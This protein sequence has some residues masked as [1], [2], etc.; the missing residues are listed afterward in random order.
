MT[1]DIRDAIIAELTDMVAALI[2]NAHEME[3]LHE[4]HVAV[5]VENTE[6][7]ILL[8]EHRRQKV[9]GAKLKTL[10]DTIADVRPRINQVIQQQRHDDGRSS[11]SPASLK[12]IMKSFSAMSQQVADLSD[13]VQTSIEGPPRPHASEALE[14]W[15]DVRRKTKVTPKKINT[16]YNRIKDFIAFVG[17][18][19]VDKYT[20]LEFQRWSNL[21][22]R[23]P[24]LISVV[25][26]LKGKTHQQAADHNDR[27]K[28]PRATM[29]TK[30]I[31]TNYFSPLKHFFRQMA[32]EHRFQSPF[33]DADVRMDG[34]GS[35]KRR[36]FKVEQLNMWFAHAAQEERAEMIWLPLL[37]AI[38]GARIA[39][40]I[41][42]QGRDIYQMENSF[43]GAKYWVID[44]RFELVA[45]DGGSEERKTK[46]ET[47]KRII[48]LHE[49][50]TEAGFIDYVRSRR[51]ADWLFPASF[52]HGKKRV[53]DPPRAA[54]KRMNRMLKDVG[55]HKP[56]ERVF[57]STRHT[58]KDIMRLARVDG[59]TSDLQT[60][61]AFKTVSGS[62]GAKDLEELP[63]EIEV[64]T[65][66]PLPEGLDL[67]PYMERNDRRKSRQ[68]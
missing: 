67:S 47:S 39:E 43:T 35:V 63:T 51:A 38:T 20:F 59:R 2:T 46:T 32:A 42:L 62:Y 56:M 6:R 30:T 23:V 15:T 49:V 31:E 45:E 26:H 21:L 11:E 64:L 9:L 54:S 25:P 58:A 36:P 48:A 5:E 41:F 37:G 1:A 7:R 14:M 50:F 44:L 60:G 33:G 18:K 17:D 53:A 27:L 3:V 61:H 29:T 68:E 66:L 13:R 22:A 19:A 16:D 57:H 34:R 12:L 28:I 10:G 24:K 4:K 8:E 52:Y 40:L 55:I 65:A